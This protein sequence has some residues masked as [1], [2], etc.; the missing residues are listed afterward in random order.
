M[1]NEQER[2]RIISGIVEQTSRQLEIRAALICG[3]PDPLEM[4]K[5]LE[6]IITD[7]HFDGGAIP[8]MYYRIAEF[9]MMVR[10]AKTERQPTTS[11]LK[12]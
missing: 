6:P 11:N 7:P 1:T 2:Q 4:V 5:W 8:P 3:A 9:E 12:H 10:R